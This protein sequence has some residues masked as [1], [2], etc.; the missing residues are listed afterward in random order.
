MM[1]WTDQFSRPAQGVMSSGS[2]RSRITAPLDL[3]TWTATPSSRWLPSSSTAKIASGSQLTRSP[4]WRSEGLMGVP[5]TS[6]TTRI[7][8]SQIVW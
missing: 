6:R 1:P 4:I 7:P 5:T 8:G 2:I 3:A